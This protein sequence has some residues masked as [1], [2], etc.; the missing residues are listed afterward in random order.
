MSP[1]PK[2]LS[3]FED[4]QPD[5]QAPLR[6]Q[7]QARAQHGIY[8]GT[9]SWKYEG[10]LGQI[11]SPERY[12]M[13]GRFS[14]KRFEQE[15]L[16]E[17]AE[18]FSTVCGDFAFYQF[19]SASFWK[20]LFERSPKQLRFSFKVPE[21]ITAP[22]FAKH[23]RYGA[24]SGHSNPTYLD[25]QVFEDLFLEPLLL[26]SNRTAVLIFEFGAVCGELF[27]PDDFAAKLEAFLSGLPPAF[28]YAVEIRN[29]EFLQSRP[30]VEALHTHRVAHVFN[31]WSRMP[32]LSQQVQ[33]PD[34]FTTDVVVV[35]ALLTRG[36]PYADAVRIFSPY[37]AIQ[38]RDPD[39][40][41]AIRDIV[42]QTRKKGETAYIYVNNRLEG[43]APST[44]HEI[45]EETEGEDEAIIVPLASAQS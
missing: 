40:R 31:A 38:Q 4:P 42:V 7:V 6:K 19:P 8:F 33:V 9:S 3:L 17:Y 22:V 30:Y 32:P 29:A 43:N 1:E 12:A 45:L 26:Y 24:R 41:S 39:V 34:I 14:K 10:W 28:R 2:T 23:P 36:R 37:Q 11:Y 16:Q 5:L 21:E 27:S 35:R 20:N 13:R 15:C 25:R 18:I 44:I